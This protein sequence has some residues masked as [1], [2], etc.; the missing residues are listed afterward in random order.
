MKLVKSKQTNVP[1]IFCPHPITIILPLPALFA[2]K[3]SDKN[4]G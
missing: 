1:F 2:K 3:V 4:N